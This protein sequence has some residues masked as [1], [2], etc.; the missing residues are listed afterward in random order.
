MLNT[1]RIVHVT[2][3]LMAESCLQTAAPFVE[4]AELPGREVVERVAVGTDEM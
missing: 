1:G 2:Q 4:Q 3:N